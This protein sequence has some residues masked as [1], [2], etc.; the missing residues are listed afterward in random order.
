MTEIRILLVDDQNLV[1]EGLKSLIQLSSAMCV[2]AEADDGSD[3][4]ELLEQF[5]PDIML[6]DIRMPKV[7]GLDVL[8]QMQAQQLTTPTLILTTFDDHDLGTL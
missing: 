2:I 8:R 1:R 4:L 7:N 6:L 3:V 5:Q